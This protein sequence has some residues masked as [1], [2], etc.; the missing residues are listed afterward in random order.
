MWEEKWTHCID[1][2]VQAPF[3][4]TAVVLE[5]IA[6]LHLGAS[7]KEKKIFTLNFELNWTRFMPKGTLKFSP[8]LL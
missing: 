7:V 3:V 6:V 8:R 4:H 1:T 5:L 2:P